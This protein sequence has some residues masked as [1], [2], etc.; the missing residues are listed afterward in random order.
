[1]TTENEENSEKVE[2]IEA[3]LKMEAKENKEDN[4]DVPSETLGAINGDSN[5]S[6]KT[7]ENE[8][9]ESKGPKKTQIPR[10][11]KTWESPDCSCSKVFSCSHLSPDPPALSVTPSFLLQVLL[12][13]GDWEQACPR[14]GAAAEL[15][16]K[17]LSV[18][19]V[20]EEELRGDIT[21]SRYF[22][23]QVLNWFTVQVHAQPR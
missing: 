8:T 5:A 21:L 13:E 12:E 20:Q 19:G 3:T 9:E 11:R 16:L 10:H 23:V 6:I 1:M 4:I 2:Q 18:Q 17:L 15:S 22:V 14:L 7:V